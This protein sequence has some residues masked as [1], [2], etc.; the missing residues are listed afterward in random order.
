M[1]VII[2][3]SLKNE[4]KLFFHYSEKIVKLNR[5]TIWK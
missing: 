1:L 2:V 4:I 3:F 5:K